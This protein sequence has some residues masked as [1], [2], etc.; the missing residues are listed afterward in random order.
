MDEKVTDT[1]NEMPGEGS[2]ATET[3]ELPATGP[4]T[5]KEILKLREKASKVDEY[6]ERLLREAADFENYKKRA[7]RERQEAITFANE[8]LLQKL[9]PVVDAFDM[10]LA[11]TASDANGAQSVRAGIVMISNQLKSVLSQAGLEE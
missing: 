10:A 11:A 4:L 2:P 9:I 1:Q 3:A 6:W 7:T 8:S 5:P